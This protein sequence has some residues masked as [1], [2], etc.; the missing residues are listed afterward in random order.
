MKKLAFVQRNN[1]RH[2]VGD[3]F[4]VRSVFSYSD[5]GAEMSPFLL[6]DYAGPASFPPS[7]QRRGV[8]AHPHRGFETVTIVYS[9]EVEHRDSSGGGG[10]IGP[11]DVQWMTAASGIVHEE[12]HGPDFAK[13]GGAFEM[14]QLWVNLA[15]KDKSANPRY[16]NI[17][18]AQIPQVSLPGDAG[19]VRVIAGSY[20]GTR[21][22]AQTFSPINLWD[23]RLTAGHRV[24]FHVPGGQ[25]TALFV[26][27]G[28]VK[29]ESGEPV[30]DAEL[31]VLDRAGETFALEALED[32]TVLILNAQ[33]I[34]EPI[35]GYGPFVMNSQAEIEQAITDYQSGRMGRIALRDAAVQHTGETR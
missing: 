13:R 27:K 12:F 25:T 32:T 8:G 10:I 3:G 14:I 5:I 35:V 26:L 17:T 22:P 2:W 11:G 4:P 9:G 31:A 30:R 21:G 15:A 7:Q 20:N 34:D 24:E 16:Q 18:H 1:Q 19:R 23:A 28:R 33:L 29:L 6:L